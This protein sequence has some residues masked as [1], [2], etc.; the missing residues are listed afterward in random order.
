VGGWRWRWNREGSLTRWGIHMWDEMG[1][2]GGIA[3]DEGGLGEIKGGEI[4]GGGWRCGWGGDCRGW[5][6]CGWVCGG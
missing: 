6:L 5:G 2:G 1:G 4:G 3:G